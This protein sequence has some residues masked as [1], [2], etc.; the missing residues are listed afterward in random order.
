[1]RRALDHGG[2]SVLAVLS[3]LLGTILGAYVPV[4][5]AQSVIS[6][7]TSNGS[8]V[9]PASL[10]GAW[11]GTTCTAGSITVSSGMIL[12]V[13]VGVTVTS[14][15]LSISGGGTVNN[16]GTISGSSSDSGIISES[17]AIVNNYGTMTGS[18]AGDG[19]DNYGTINN[20]GSMTGSSAG[21]GNGIY[22]LGGTI[23]NAGTM[24]GSAAGFQGVG[25]DNE[26]TINNDGTVTG[27]SGGLVGIA[28]IGS[29]NDYCDATLNGLSTS[30]GSV[31]NISC[32]TVNFDQ[33]G[34]PISGAPWG[35]TANWGPFNTVH[36]TGTGATITVQATGSLSYTYD[37]P[38][39]SLLTLTY[40]CSTGCTGTVSVNGPPSIISASYITAGPPLPSPLLFILQLVYFILNYL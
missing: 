5:H 8:T 25:I 34:I 6:I 1:M 10:S 26:N 13:G 38:V 7:T 40:D 35:V 28:N 21:D 18:S 2:P 27:G 19:I 20:D 37:S 17:G 3:L 39:T 4:A 11:S 14:G 30:P 22:N 33:S 24:T 15:G 29:I 31:D 12:D 23:N 36:Y 16:H 9:C 32:Y